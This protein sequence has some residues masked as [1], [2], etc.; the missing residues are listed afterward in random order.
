MMTGKAGIL[1]LHMGDLLFGTDYRD[2]LLVKQDGCLACPIRCGRHI[3]IRG[4]EG[5][6]K[7]PK[8]ITDYAKKIPYRK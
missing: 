3:K 4:R 6:L 8:W 2:E 7:T 5:K 1:H